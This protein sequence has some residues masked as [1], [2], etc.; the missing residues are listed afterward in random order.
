MTCKK[1]KG[2]FLVPNL[3]RKEKKILQ[4]F[5]IYLT[6]N[7]RKSKC[8]IVIMAQFK[9]HWGIPPHGRTS[10]FGAKSPAPTH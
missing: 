9:R 1:K 10:R 5:N 8:L 4:N 2:A 7:T 6:E 3:G